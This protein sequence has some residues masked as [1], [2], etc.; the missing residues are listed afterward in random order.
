MSKKRLSPDQIQDNNYNSVASTDLGIPKDKQAFLEN[1]S[2]INPQYS[3]EY[4]PSAVSPTAGAARR[5]DFGE[6]PFNERLGD[7][8]MPE[9]N[10]QDVYYS[11]QGGI[12][13]AAKFLGRSASGAVMK[14]LQGVAILGSGVAEGTLAAV[15]GGLGL[16]GA[17]TGGILERM[18]YDGEFDLDDVTSNPVVDTL[19]KAEEYMNENLFKVYQP[20]NWNDKSFFEQVIDGAWWGNEGADGVAFALSN[21]IPAGILGKAGLG[22]KA[23]RG[24]ADLGEMNAFTKFM[25]AGKAGLLRAENIGLNADRA[26]STAFMTTNEALFEAKD[27]GDTFSNQYL[28]NYNEANGTQFQTAEELAEVNPQA[29]EDLKAK[30][31]EAMKHTFFANMAALSASNWIEAGLLNKFMGKTSKSL[32]GQELN[33]GDFLDPVTAVQRKGLDKFFNGTRL[34]S[35]I[36]TVG[37][38]M[39]TEGLYEENIQHAIQNVSQNM[40]LNG[41]I[42]TMK[43]MENIGKEMFANL[44]DKEAWKSIGAG[45]VIGGMFGGISNAGIPG[46]SQGAFKEKQ[47]TI[48]EGIAKLNEVSNNL[49]NVGQIY[50]Q[51]G[52]IDTD[53]LQN[54]VGN[55]IQAKNIQAIH[56]EYKGRGE[57]ELA[58]IVK[59]EHV[60]NYV[61]GFMEAGLEDDLKL[62]MKDLQ[63][64]TEDDLVNFGFDPME[65]DNDGNKVTVAQRFQELSNKVNDYAEQYKYLNKVIP[66]EQRARQGEALS[67]YARYKHLQGL[68]NKLNTQKSKLNLSIPQGQEAIASINAL[69]T[70]HAN[71]SKELPNQERFS[72]PIRSANRRSELLL[73]E[74]EIEEMKNANKEALTA[75]GVE[76]TPKAEKLSVSETPEQKQYELIDRTSVQVENA[77]TDA[78][79]KYIGLVDEKGG[80][81]FYQQ[82]GQKVEELEEESQREDSS[83]Y[84]EGDYLEVTNQQGQTQSGFVTLNDSGQRVF[85]NQV[86]NDNFS[87]ANQVNK[88]T[89]EQVQELKDTAVEDFRKKQ[90]VDRIVR[91]EEIISKI[92]ERVKNGQEHILNQLIEKEDIILNAQNGTVRLTEKQLAKQLGQIERSINDA[93][94]LITHLEEGLQ[95]FENELNE[96]RYVYDTPE[97]IED[98][99]DLITRTEEEIVEVEKEIAKTQPLLDRLK[100]V[101]FSMLN[102]WRSLFPSKEY[103]S[104]EDRALEIEEAIERGADPAT[105]EQEGIGIANK[106]SDYTDYKQDL[107]LTG[108]EMRALQ[109]DLDE[110]KSLRGL[111]YTDLENLNNKLNSYQLEANKLNYAKVLRADTGQKETKSNPP[112]IVKDTS[113]SNPFS[114]KRTRDVS[115]VLYSTAGSHTRG[116]ELTN[117]ETQLRWFK[118]AE[119]YNPLKGNYKLRTV[120]LNDSEYGIGSN[121]NIY[122]DD[123]KEYQNDTHFKLLV[124]D[125]DNNPVYRDGQ[126]V[127]TSMAQ[128]KEDFSKYGNQEKW[129]AEKIKDENESYKGLLTKAK[130]EPQYLDITN[131][132][133]G[134]PRKGEL[135]SIKKAFGNENVEL[136]LITDSNTVVNEKQYPLFKGLVYAIYDGR[137]VGLNIRPLT[138]NERD[139]SIERLKEYA[140]IRGTKE[141]N[142]KSILKQLTSTFFLGQ[143]TENPQLSIFFLKGED[144]LVFGDNIITHQEL[145]DGKYD[146]QLDQFLADINHHVDNSSLNKKEEYRDITGKKWDNYNQYL[147]QE[148]EDAPLMSDLRPKSDDIRDPQFVNTYLEFSTP[149]AKTKAKPSTGRGKSKVDFSEG[150]NFTVIPSGTGIREQLESRTEAKIDR[151][152]QIDPDNLQIPDNLNVRSFESVLEEPVKEEIEKAGTQKEEKIKVA[153]GVEMSAS[154]MADIKSMK[155]AMMADILA[156]TKEETVDEKPIGSD[157][158]FDL[159]LSTERV[160]EYEPINFEQEEKWFRDN[161][162]TTLP[163]RKVA[164]LIEN[165]AFGRFTSNGEI[166]ISDAATA[167]TGYHEAFHVVSNLYLSADQQT[168]LYNEWLGKNKERLE[169]L[170]KE[171]IY[172]GKS[173]SHIAEEELAE[174]FREYML[175][176]QSEYSNWFDKIV[177]FIK[178]LIGLNT[179]QQEKL[180]SKIKKGSFKDAESLIRS[181]TNLYSVA[182]L[183]GATAKKEL[184]DGLTVTLFG[185]LFKNGFDVADIRAFSQD[186]LGKEKVSKFSN[187]YIDSYKLVLDDIKLN[188]SKQ[189]NS[190]MTKEDFVKM[191]SDDKMRAAVIAM[192]I[193]HLYQFNL[194]FKL[195]EDTNLDTLPEGDKGRDTL[196]IVDSIE[197][198]TKNSMPDAVKLLIASLPQVEINEKGKKQLKRSGL[199]LLIPTDSRRN[200]AILH[201]ELAGINDFQE[202]LT[203]IEKLTTKIPE[204]SIMLQ[205]LKTGESTSMEGFYLQSQFRQQFDKNRY[206]FFM[207]L[208]D[209]SNSYIVDANS[210]RMIDLIKSKWQGALRHNN[211]SIKVVDGLQKLNEVYFAKY[212]N[213]GKDVRQSVLS[214]YKDLGITFSNPEEVNIDSLADTMKALMIDIKEG[215]VDANIFDVDGIKGYMN[216]VIEQEVKTSLDYSD[217][218]HINP[219]GKTVYNISLND[220]LSIEANEMNRKGLPEHLVWNEE[221]GTGNP[222]VRNSVWADKIRKGKKINTI[223]LEGARVDE[224]GETG[225]SMS[226]LTR[227]EAAV[228]QFTSVLEGKFP[229]LRA[230]DKG[231]EKG[232]TFGE[233]IGDLKVQEANQ[234]MRGYLADELLSAY[235]LNNEGVGEDIQYYNKLGTKLRIFEGVLSKADQKKADS[236]MKKNRLDRKA[237]I[238]AIDAFI[239]T[240]SVMSA[241]DSYLDSKISDNIQEL[242]NNRVLNQEQNGTYTNLGLPTEIVER[243]IGESDTITQGQLDNIVGQFTYQSLIANIEQTKM[244]TGDIAFFKDFFKRTSGLVGTGKTAWVGQYV[245]KLINNLFPRSDKQSDSKIKSWIFNDVI[246]SSEVLEDYIKAYQEAGFT[247]EEAIKILRNYRE[248]NEADGQGYV[249]LPEYREFNLRMGDWNNAREEVYQKALAGQQLSKEDVQMLNPEKPQMYAPQE[250]EE[251]YVPTFYKFSIIPLIPSMI[252]GRTLEKLNEAMLKEKV[253]FAI[254]ESGNKVGA[255]NVRPF[256]NANGEF[257]TDNPEASH[258]LSYKYMKKQLDIN[259]ETKDKVIFGTQFRKLILSGLNKMKITIDGKK[260]D[261]TEVIKEFNGL[262]DKQINL[263]TNRLIKE[264]GIVQDGNNFRVTN[265]ETLKEMLKDEALKR[266]APDN[267]VESLD[268]IF[269]QGDVKPVEL[270]VNRNKIEQILMSLVNNNI[271][272]QKVNGGLLVQAAST[273]F[274]SSARK[275]ADIENNVWASNLET[276]KFYRPSKKGTLAMEVYLPYKFKELMGVDDIGTIDERL[277]QLIAFRIPTQGLNSIEAINV[278]GFLPREAGDIIIV[279][280]EGVTKSGWDF[281]VD[282]LNVFF[283]NYSFNKFT[284]KPE[285]VEDQ[286]SAEGVQ[287]RLIELS[288]QILLSNENFVPLTTPNTT[289]TL[290]DMEKEIASLNPA[291][292]RNDNQRSKFVDWAYNLEIR[293]TYLLGKTG[294]GQA[295]L[296]NV[297]HVMAQ[298]AGLGMKK[299]SEIYLKHHTD[300]E[301]NID[302]SQ[303]K[304]VDDNNTTIQDIISQTLNGFVDIAKEPF[305]KTLNITPDTS[306]IFFFLTRIGTPLRQTTLFLNQPII[307]DYLAE[308]E[309]NKALFL[310][311]KDELSRKDL[312]QKI[313]DKWTGNGVELKT[314]DDIR[315][316]LTESKLSGYIKNGGQDKVAQIAILEEFMNY[317]KQAEQLV[318]LIQAVNFDTSSSAS[319]EAARTKVE[320]LQD[321]IKE[322]KFINVK[323]MMTDTFLGSFARATRDSINLYKDLFI[324][325]KDSNIRYRLDEVKR[326]FKSV[327]GMDVEKA[328]NTVKNDMISY[329]I[330]N[331][332][333]GAETKLGNFINAIF[334]DKRSNIATT[335]SSLKESSLGNNYLIRELTP[336]LAKAS[337]KEAINSDD[338][339]NLKMFTKRLVVEEQNLVTDAWRELFEYQGINEQETATVQNL[340]YDLMYMAILQSGLNNSPLSFTQFIPNEYYLELS[341]KLIDNVLDDNSLKLEEFRDKFY[342]NNYRSNDIVPRVKK[343][344]KRKDGTI[345]HF[346]GRPYIKTWNKG[347]KSFKLYRNTYDM[348]G[349]NYIFEET[350]K[351]GDG[352]NFKEFASTTSVLADNN[353]G[354]DRN[355]TKVEKGKTTKNKLIAQVNDSDLND[356]TKA[357]YIKRIEEAKDIQQIS[358]VVKELCK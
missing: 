288:R 298:I 47:Q 184:M 123:T 309:T 251:L 127:F 332:K 116:D 63:K 321:L 311:E 72:L 319:I 271:I 327:L 106:L 48:Q 161:I 44:G 132:S 54:F 337:R 66:S 302:L 175:T 13:T 233:N 314:D 90:V 215:D 300:A 313:R 339:N 198:S 267:L 343:V 341:S 64:Y 124:V 158:L 299:E 294:V 318:E 248:N 122:K 110:L 306:N 330:Q 19:T 234:I 307:R 42:D 40:A 247:K 141:G 295:A 100:S 97:T 183:L 109:R 335:V 224:T 2:N 357:E 117:D 353:I 312:E 166:L 190:R 209:G 108:A 284:R 218:Q 192:H 170:R 352:F 275:Q 276:L 293:Q 165:G 221:T 253:G 49:R 193:K 292:A 342:K 191:L 36:A 195:E 304:D 179:N 121:N 235:M 277:K 208:Y 333:F 246:T 60:A 50:K 135:I 188:P 305:L 250:Y 94:D 168:N 281:D 228:L 29:A 154:D 12:E 51:D 338:V 290:T 22:A 205:K 262:I 201:N 70:K 73:L 219:E 163:F 173:D 222:L 236:I 256:Y 301:G 83:D 358:D 279:P 134:I 148:R 153:G 220:Y 115:K 128:P 113:K 181:N 320:K 24:L 152:G 239:E 285:Y 80:E 62:K 32:L 229:F 185:N 157:S 325:E 79:D 172:Q 244:F 272:K 105:F 45:M 252:K 346:S 3:G 340:G 297:N 211:K 177:K 57:N 25:T 356:K 33:T 238:K 322:D 1:L 317:K 169:D 58:D 160:T 137:P 131:R 39:A 261:G 156:G 26:V 315:N 223:I 17:F 6:T 167:G 103:K 204:L 93:E 78:K 263:E 14:A 8:M 326:D 28:Q 16:G 226:N 278:K 145:I 316:A 345:S 344:T 27:T 231:L 242:V 147:V 354:A 178:G 75:M 249:T 259:P 125:A 265:T 95:N 31:G 144:K 227:G 216:R 88:L 133:N 111:L 84:Q 182:K 87:T 37:Q 99:Q 7:G 260:V 197:F 86:I 207:Q 331:S 34:G 240:P 71:L 126:L 101:Y 146:V 266:T 119:S 196:G 194:K 202:Q 52:T 96:L 348:D 151:I 98:V 232:F 323:E 53:K 329:L 286:E 283:P 230:G 303:E 129:S 10:E 350:N 264:L 282:K 245:D 171:E 139:A 4:S 76:V 213:L 136:K 38:Q 200:I 189:I 18:G 296:Q 164:G 15:D 186:E 130:V 206:S 291:L 241:I 11:N 176:D 287:N 107:Q 59:N 67:W 102:T 174:E 212:D 81:E 162:S 89:E 74:K 149:K 273:G 324:T 243:Y 23:A 310:D 180:F 61:K 217:N 114:D 20:S 104:L 82:L 355:T 203:A 347:K 68:S 43:F 21:F 143:R 268:L 118:F 142:G 140:K 308:L 120:S 92:K 35:T 328:M 159:D 46:V 30:K 77:L 55:L 351:L 237:T 274:E 280:T 138:Q 69:A 334:I 270:S 349:K 155:A 41:K 199:G 254:F 289:E 258:V 214:F 5:V 210:S 56:D 225:K 255:R 85:G 150:L 336:I 9:L 257:N 65:M 91:L 269:K 187:I 112:A